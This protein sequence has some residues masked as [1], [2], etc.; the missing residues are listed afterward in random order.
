MSEPTPE[1]PPAP[2]A[3]EPP[4]PTPA[5]PEPAA[6]PQAE[7]QPSTPAA[8]SA[9]S[10]DELPSWAQREFKKL[11]DE[12]AGNRVKAKEVTDSLAQFKAE[13]DQQRQAFAK[14]LGLAP[15]EPPTA[16]QLTEQLNATKAERDA[17]QARARQT[18]V[19]LAVFRAAAAEQVDGN[20]LLDSRAFVSALDG[21]DPSADNFGQQVKDAIAAASEANPRYK[22]APPAPAA[23]EPPA[24]PAVPKS[25][26][27]FGAP[28]QGPRQWTEEDVA[29]AAPAQVQEA[30]NKGLLVNLG[31]GPRRGARR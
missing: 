15:D 19:E 1:T 23:P 10:V 6:A 22:L 17:Q 20:A 8:P 28:P 3:P 29:R 25:G 13:Q 21:L 2:A 14:A 18:A 24:P 4:T 7:P 16:E 5:A 12:A 31:F 27:E 26:A 11:R 9:A 30:I